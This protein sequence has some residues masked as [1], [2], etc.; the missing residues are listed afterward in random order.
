MGA[1]RLHPLGFVGK[2]TGYNA[3]VNLIEKALDSEKLGGRY[4]NRRVRTRWLD[5]GRVELGS[6]DTGG[7][8]VTPEIRYLS[9]DM[10]SGVWLRSAET[11]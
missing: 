2:T 10:P 11:R 6:M 7:G 8:T 4:A 9:A 1:W 3:K 5:D